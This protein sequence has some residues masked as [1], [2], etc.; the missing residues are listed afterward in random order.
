MQKKNTFLSLN[1][2]RVMDEKMTQIFKYIW[3]KFNVH[4]R[5]L[6][7]YGRNTMRT[8]IFFQKAKNMLSIIK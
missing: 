7:I 8:L 5:Y 3:Q 4:I 1:F 6:N 2:A